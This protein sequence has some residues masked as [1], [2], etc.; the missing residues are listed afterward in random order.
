MLPQCLHVPSLFSWMV[1]ASGSGIMGL[2]GIFFSVVF[3][4]LRRCFRRKIMSVL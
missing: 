3:S 2:R 4:L 1:V